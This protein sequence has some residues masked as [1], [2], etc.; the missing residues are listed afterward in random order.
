MK[1]YQL[2]ESNQG[3]LD[4]GILQSMTFITDQQIKV[5]L[6]YLIDVAKKHLI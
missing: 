3:C 4:T 5:Q 1:V 2:K 6:L